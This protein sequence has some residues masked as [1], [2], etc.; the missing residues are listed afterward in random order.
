MS[1]TNYLST[2]HKLLSGH[3]GRPR[4]S[5]L[6]KAMSASYYAAFY[7]LCKN[8]ADCFIGASKAG[9]SEPAWQQVFR[10]TEHGLAKR[11]CANQ[12]VMQRFPPE[13]QAFAAKFRSL[14]DKR[15]KADYDPGAN[16]SLD[17]AQDCL[18]AA[19]EAITE[20]S[21]ADLKDRRAFAAWVTMRG[22][23]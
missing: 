21:K 4:Q 6:K 2:A 13:I 16:L 18:D 9:R 5:D 1:P 22:R 12:Q 7:A 14:Q 15:H 19:T 23:P 8:N 20:L 10:A 11:R 3:T 17:E